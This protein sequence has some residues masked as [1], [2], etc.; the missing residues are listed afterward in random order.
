MQRIEWL[1]RLPGAVPGQDQD[2]SNETIVVR[3]EWPTIGRITELAVGEAVIVLV[4]SETDS[5]DVAES[6]VEPPCNR[7]FRG[8]MALSMGIKTQ[9]SG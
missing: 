5:G 9:F 7:I 8:S 3:R 4:D 1:I 2:P 6:Q